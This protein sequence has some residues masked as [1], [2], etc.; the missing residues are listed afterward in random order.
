[1]SGRFC[2]TAEAKRTDIFWLRDIRTSVDC[3]ETV[4]RKW[5]FLEDYSQPFATTTCEDEQKPTDRPNPRRDQD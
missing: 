2:V 1:M 3:R 4:K 5:E